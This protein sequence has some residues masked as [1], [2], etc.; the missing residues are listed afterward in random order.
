MTMNN[1]KKSAP[2]NCPLPSAIV[3]GVVILVLIGVAIYTMI[4]IPYQKAIDLW[5]GGEDV[6]YPN[7]KTVPPEW[8]NLFT[9]KKEPI[10]FVIN[11]QKGNLTRTVKTHSDGSSTITLTYTFDY[12]YDDF[13]QDIALYFKTQFLKKQPFA[14]LVWITPDGRKISFANF[15]VPSRVYLSHITRLGPANEIERGRPHDCPVHRSK[16]KQKTEE[17]RSNQ[18]YLPIG[19]HRDRLGERFGFIRRVRFPGP[20]G[21]IGRNGLLPA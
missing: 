11:A 15:G 14:S 12:K 7:P 8:Y 9:S 17:P 10:S 1:F 2:G 6:W 16:S 13:P 5:R 18:G 21:R 19:G 3:G 4:A 20:G